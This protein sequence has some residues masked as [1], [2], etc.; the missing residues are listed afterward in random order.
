MRSNHVAT[1][2]TGRRKRN[3]DFVKCFNCGEMGHFARDCEK[4][5]K[6]K[7]EDKTPVAMSACAVEE[8]ETECQWR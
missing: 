3:L 8:D 4:E 7:D 5:K 6:E 1:K 2:W